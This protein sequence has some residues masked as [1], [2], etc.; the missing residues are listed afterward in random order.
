MVGLSGCTT[1][2]ARRIGPPRLV[3]DDINALLEN[4]H[5]L[6]C[7][8][9]LQLTEDEL[10]Q[11]AVGPLARLLHNHW[12]SKRRQRHDVPVEVECRL[13]PY[14]LINHPPLCTH[15]RTYKQAELDSPLSE[16]DPEPVSPIVSWTPST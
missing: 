9:T 4:A 15:K 5:K 6:Q 3:F 8:L 7:T 14:S 2:P 12:T 1:G 16:Q 11:P 10:G 13:C